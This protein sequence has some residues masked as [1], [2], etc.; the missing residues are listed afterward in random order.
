MTVTF[1]LVSSALVTFHTW[2]GGANKKPIECI[3]NGKESKVSKNIRM[4]FCECAMI[5][6]HFARLISGL[7]TSVG[8]TPR[9]SQ[10]AII[11]GLREVSTC[12][13][14]ESMR[15]KVRKCK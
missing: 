13:A 5:L 15:T 3:Y 7:T 4:K 1:L 6:F 10:K 11:S 9:D 2:F 12:E 14:R 8:C